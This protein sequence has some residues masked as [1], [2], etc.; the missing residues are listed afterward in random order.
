MLL[1]NKAFLVF[2]ISNVLPE[3]YN[4][5]INTTLTKIQNEVDLNKGAL[6][7]CIFFDTGSISNSITIVMA[8]HLVIDFV[9][10][11]IIL[12]QY[13]EGINSKKVEFDTL[14]RTT[15]LNSWA[16]HL[17]HLKESKAILK[18]QNYW[19]KQKRH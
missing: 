8:H 9:S 12:E 4:S 1:P 16:N 14:Y 17:N 2:D 19:E 7:K 18:E 3:N 6:F 15:S 10:W 11:Q 13:I 5:E